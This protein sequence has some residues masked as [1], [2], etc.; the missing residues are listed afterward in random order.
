MLKDIRDTVGLQTEESV[1]AARAEDRGV[2][3]DTSAGLRAGL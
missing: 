3:E 1:V 2:Q